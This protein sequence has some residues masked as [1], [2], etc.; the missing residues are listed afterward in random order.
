MGWGV[1]G[2]A[3]RDGRKHVLPGKEVLNYSGRYRKREEGIFVE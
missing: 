1:Y 3:S 2:E